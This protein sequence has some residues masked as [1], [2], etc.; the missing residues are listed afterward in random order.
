MGGILEKAALAA[1]L[2]VVF[3]ADHAAASPWGQP[4][5]DSFRSIKTD[6]YRSGEDDRQFE[7]MVLETYAEQGFFDRWSL[8]GKLGSTWQRVE[9][10]GMT[11]IRTGLSD[12]EIFIQRQ[13]YG[14][15]TQAAAIQLLYGFETTTRSALFAEEIDG[16]SAAIGLSGLW[17][18]GNEAAFI[19]TRG[20]Y[21]ASL[22]DDADQFKL[23]VTF[24]LHTDETS[25]FLLDIYSTF[26]VGD[27]EAGGA[28]FDLV[29]VAPSLVMR[30]S[31]HVRIQF[32]ARRDVVADGL[33]AGTGGFIAL[34]VEP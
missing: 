9:F 10:G 30:A 17:G 32:G 21:R 7:Q 31:P 24:G 11:D 33:D 3:F 1:S 28:E 25:M 27:A 29:T 16:R 22:G 5:Q 2:P 20:G 13:M 6:Y 34:W 4:D 23:D 15:E 19:S 14:T 12:A 18:A 8:G 26:A